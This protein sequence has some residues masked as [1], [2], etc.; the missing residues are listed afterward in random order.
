MGV[1]LRFHGLR[2]PSLGANPMHQFFGSSFFLETRILS[3]ALE[4]LIGFLAYLE[5]KL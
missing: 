1:F 5:P 4:P 2:Y 3:E